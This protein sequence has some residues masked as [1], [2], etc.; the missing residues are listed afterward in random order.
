MQIP[1]MDAVRSKRVGILQGDSFSVASIMHDMSVPEKHN[2]NFFRN[3]RPVCIQ[4]SE[5]I[6][7]ENVFR[8]AQ[9][10]S[11]YNFSEAFWEE[12]DKMYRAVHEDHDSPEEFDFNRC[13]DSGEAGEFEALF[14]SDINHLLASDGTTHEIWSD[15]L[16][17]AR[18]NRVEDSE[19]GDDVDIFTEDS[20][21]NSFEESDFS[22][23]RY[24]PSEEQV[25][26]WGLYSY[27]YEYDGQEMFSLWY[28]FQTGDASVT[29]VPL[30]DYTSEYTSVVSS[31]PDFGIVDDS[32]ISDDLAESL[33]TGEVTGDLTNLEQRLVESVQDMNVGERTSEI[34]NSATDASP[35]TQSMVAE[36]L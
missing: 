35:V 6:S 14:L 15:F 26:Y 25:N 18:W 27:N 5:P 34:L 4:A 16:A 33:E 22:E 1:A 21:D 3:A 13:M 28:R 8:N 29:E 23:Q 30:I 31:N 17:D 12:A 19:L 9:N 32:H 7:L 36:E 10:Y 2:G 11:Q 20:N 24:L